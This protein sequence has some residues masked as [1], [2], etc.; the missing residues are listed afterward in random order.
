MVKPPLSRPSPPSSFPP[1]P[2]PPSGLPLFVRTSLSLSIRVI[3]TP[4]SCATRATVTVKSRLR[5][6]H[7]ETRRR[8]QPRQINS[9]R[10]HQRAVQPTNNARKL[11]RGT[12][13]K[14]ALTN[15]APRPHR[16]P[17]HHFPRQVTVRNNRSKTK[18]SRTSGGV[19]PLAMRFLARIFARQ[20]FTLIIN[21]FYIERK[22]ARE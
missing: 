21:A 1:P 18:D 15:I 2:P 10:R 5:E 8:H 4:R 3:R 9:C 22:R 13:C 11:H 17:G 20:K 7:S 16:R 14:N 6:T 12:V 19:G